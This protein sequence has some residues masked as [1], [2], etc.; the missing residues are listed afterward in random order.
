[1][2]KRSSKIALKHANRSKLAQVNAY[3]FNEYI[4]Q[5]VQSEI[6]KAIYASKIAALPDQTYTQAL[7]IPASRQAQLVAKEISSV[8]RSTL[9]KVKKA[10]LAKNPQKYQTEIL[11]KYRN[12]TLAIKWKGN[13]SLDSRFVS[14]EKSNTDEFDF[15]VKITFSK[16]RNDQSTTPD[17]VTLPL[18]QTKHMTKLEADGFVLKSTTAKL[19]RDGSIILFYEREPN[20]IADT[21]VMG[22]DVGQIK[23]FVTSDN[24]RS[25]PTIYQDMQKLPIKK[26]GSQRKARLDRRIKTMQ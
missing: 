13:F 20:V 12:K 11:E 2:I 16:A 14:I 25:D 22:I 1:M 18:Y 24:Q 7:G 3:F 9:A 23:A 6:N 21:G 17:S 26:H 10:E 8:A 4:E 5:I 19:C 15:W